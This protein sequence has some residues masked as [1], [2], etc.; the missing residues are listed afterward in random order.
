M[1]D[2]ESFTENSSTNGSDDEV[3]MNDDF[4]CNVVRV[5]LVQPYQNEPTQSKKKTTAA[6]EMDKS[7]LDR[8]GNTS[9]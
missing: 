1:S 2:S 9:W 3:E 7:N 5:G 4:T 6:K 8:V